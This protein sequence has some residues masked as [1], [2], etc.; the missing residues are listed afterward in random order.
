MRLSTVC[1]RGIQA[2][3]A[4]GRTST[5]WSLTV[6]WSANAAF[7]WVRR[8]NR[9]LSI[10]V[11]RRAAE[12]KPQLP[13]QFWV[14]LRFGLPCGNSY[15]SDL[16]ISTPKHFVLYALSVGSLRSFN[17]ASSWTHPRSARVLV[18][19]FCYPCQSPPT[20]TCLS[21]FPSILPTPVY[22]SRESLPVWLVPYSAGPDPVLLRGVAFM[23]CMRLVIHSAVPVVLSL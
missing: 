11:C 16:V 9:V 20:T 4:Q 22:P 1:R 18:I 21:R 8:L 15:S 12:S 14:R 7:A 23:W 2:A 6:V 3:P 5:P 19:L 17:V 13:C 10:Y